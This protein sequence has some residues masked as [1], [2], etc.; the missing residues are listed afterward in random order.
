MGACVSE[1]QGEGAQQ[2][3]SDLNGVSV[4]LGRRVGMQSQRRPA[5]GT[6]AVPLTREGP[7]MPRNEGRP[8]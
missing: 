2:L 5:S 3:G 7:R 1:G 4:L 8:V 6:C